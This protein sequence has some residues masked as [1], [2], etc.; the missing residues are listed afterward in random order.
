MKLH[1]LHL[2]NKTSYIIQKKKHHT[3]HNISKIKIIIGKKKPKPLFVYNKKII[4]NEY[5]HQVKIH[6]LKWRMVI[7]KFIIFS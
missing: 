3:K 2:L 7:L 5:Y 1:I 6:T 4:I